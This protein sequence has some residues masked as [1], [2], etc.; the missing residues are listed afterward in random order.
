MATYPALRQSLLP[1]TPKQLF[2]AWEDYW[3][4]LPFLLFISLPLLALILRVSPGEFVGQLLEKQTQEALGLSLLTSLASILLTVLAG[5]PVAYLLSKKHNRFTRL[6][7]VLVDLP[8]VL[9]PA[10]AGL[11]LLITF[12]R[13]GLLGSLLN[14]WGIQ[15]AFT[16]AAVIMAQVFIAAPFYIKAAMAGFISVD[17]EIKQAAALD[18]ANEW[19]TFH[20]I[21]IP[22]VWH[23][24][25]IGIV[26]SWA[27]ALGEFG[28]TI[29]FAG[30][31]PAKTQ[32]MPLA[33]YLGFESGL[34][35]A[36]TLAVILLLFSLAALWAVKQLMGREG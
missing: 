9:P 8:T 3:L 21:I 28:A 15:I 7:D 13:R 6:I 24:I 31:L 17:P 2:F 18:G 20:Y 10:V 11:A 25:L 27:R 14:E 5:T 22:L 16:P 35:S 36:F 26:M 34:D 12:G 19:Q 30:N 32:T 33:I 1:N 4:S 29:L 23:S